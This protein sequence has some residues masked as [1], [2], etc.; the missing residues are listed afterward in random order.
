M[1]FAT[2]AIHAGQE[3][4]PNYGDV[5]PPLHMTS[6]YAFEPS[7]ETRAGFD[8]IRYGNPTRSALET[9]LASLENAPDDCPALCY[10][11]G[12][13]AIDGALRLLHPGERLLMA[14]DVYGGTVKLV[15]EVLRPAGIV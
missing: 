6:I 10:S 12:M 14:Q 11:S 8:Y 15:A 5:V 9:C 2:R 13:A 1:E 3:N 4:D 7:G